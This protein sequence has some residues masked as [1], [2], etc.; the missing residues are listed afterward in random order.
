MGIAKYV[1]RTIN[2]D[3]GW[4]P[5]RATGAE[6]ALVVG[7]RVRKLREARGWTLYRLAEEVIRPDGVF[8]SASTFSRLERGSSGSPFYVYLQLAK[9]LRVDPGRLLG[10][11]SALLEASEGEL[12]LLR[13][14]R[15]M[16]VT[17]AEAL[18][19]LLQAR[20]TAMRSSRP[21]M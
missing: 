13:T 1:P 15:L 2:P 11:D 19:Q 6:W 14:L 10:E 20:S 16:E 12:T 5:L 4:P 3:R 8:Y 21:S 9:A 18:A 7:G 17:P